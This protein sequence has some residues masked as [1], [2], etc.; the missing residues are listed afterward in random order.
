MSVEIEFGTKAGADDAREEHE[1]YICPVDDDARLKT[2]AF[3]SDLPDRVR[4]Q[5]EAGAQAGRVERDVGPGQAELTDGEKRRLGPFT[6]S[7]NYLKATSVKALLL[8]N[9]ISDWEAYYDPKLSVDEHRHQLGDWRADQSGGDVR[10][11]PSKEDRK[12]DAKKREQSH[13]EGCDHARD[14]CEHGDAGACEFLTSHCGMDDDEVQAL[15]SDD[16]PDRE[17]EIGG[18]ALGALG[19]AWQGYKA[20]IARFDRELDDATEAKQNAEQAAAAINAIRADY[21]QEPLEFERLESL[22]DQLQTAGASAHDAEGH[23]EEGS[24]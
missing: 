14:H 15:L 3:V 1:Q 4:D 12:R 9:G 11:G 20:G 18:E 24:A 19:R 16:V 23:L 2:V 5:L 8:D 13:G 7:N 10:D 21:G 6:G 17:E 22:S